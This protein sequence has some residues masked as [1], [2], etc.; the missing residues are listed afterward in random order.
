MSAAELGRKLNVYRNF[1]RHFA[2][3]GTLLPARRI[4]NGMTIH[5]SFTQAPMVESIHRQVAKI[6]AQEPNRQLMLKMGLEPAPMGP[7]DF[8][9]FMR[10]DIEKWLKVGREMGLQR[11]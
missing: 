3:N 9:A 10:A 7:A 1:Q 5:A 2:P 6:I 11:E 8:G 4:V